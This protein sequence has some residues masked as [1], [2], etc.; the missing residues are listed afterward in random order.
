MSRSQPIITIFGLS[1]EGYIIASSLST[2]DFQTILIDENMQ[3]SMRLKK[4]IFPKYD[5]VKALLDSETLIGVEPIEKSIANANYII[6]T[7]KIRGSTLEGKSVINARIRS[8]GRYLQKNV[9]FISLLPTGQDGNQENMSLLEKITGLQAETDFNYIYAPTKPGTTEL[10]SLGSNKQQNDK[11]TLKLLNSIFTNVPTILPL[12]QSELFHLRY[13][14]KRFCSIAIEFEICKKVSTL[15]Q[16]S[17][18]KEFHDLGNI[19]LEDIMSSL[20]DIRFVS[21]TCKTG[22]PI[23]YIL[24]GVIK[25]IESYFRHLIDK[26]R[27]VLREEGL[28]ASRIR[29]LVAWSVDPYEIRGDKTS[30]LSTLFEKLR[31]CVSDVTLFDKPIFHDVHSREKTNIIVACSKKDFD[32]VIKLGFPLIIKANLPVEIIKTNSV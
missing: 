12:D 31:D 13:L 27:L 19:F 15:T 28:K 11:K 21:E 22:E 16:E 26:I 18:F 5:S 23:T 32:R 6:F 1:S 20:L 7:P 4:D 17:Y 3:V 14:V 24:S 30:T 10:C 25:S 29:I 2:L 9:T 8:L